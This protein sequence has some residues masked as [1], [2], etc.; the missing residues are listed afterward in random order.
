MAFALLWPTMQ[1]SL[2]AVAAAAL[3][4]GMTVLAFQTGG[5]FDR[6][7]V[8]AAA[9]AWALV[10]LAAVFGRTPLPLSGPGRAA[11]AGLLLL[12][13]WTG[14]SILWAPVAGRAQDDLE[15]VLLYLGFF[16][17]AVAFLRGNG[18]RR[19][20]EPSLV[21]VVLVVV[22]YGL[23]ERLLPGLIELER[24]STSSGRLEQPLT[25][26]NAMGIVAAIGLLL[27]VRVAGDPERSR[28]LRAAAAAGGVV[29][30]FGLYLTFARGALA[31][32]AVGLVV[33]IGLAPTVRP[34]LRSIFVVLAASAVAALVANF[35]PAVKSLERG[36]PGDTAEGLAMLLT[37]TLLAAVAPLIALRRPRRRWP[38][39]H[40]PGRR[41]ITVL[42][43]AGVFVLA[44]V[45][46]VAALEGKPENVSPASG[47][48]PARLASID[49]NR[50]G[51]WKV[52]IRE[53]VDHPVAG[54]GSG[55]FA[56][57]WLKER[58]RE[59][60]A[61]DAHSLYIETAAE[62]G[63]VGLGFLLLFA[64][65]VGIALG[66]L[67]RLSPGAA[68]GLS[69][70]LAAWACHAGL[71]WDWEL[72]AA[73]LPALLLAAAAITGSEDDAARE[74]A[75]QRHDRKPTVARDGVPA[76]ASGELPSRRS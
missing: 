10:A 30:G 63:L 44:G 7:R 22:G 9:G 24:S 4:G 37:L 74:P 34:L 76:A 27:A 53:A 64:A 73:T 31:A 50:Y 71:D 14:L 36:Q 68:T 33:L 39:P 23:S 69:A 25:Y 58:D 49:T 2:P 62:L 45:V 42:T 21:L 52:A 59:D 1:R 67:Y 32:L 66:R 47:T 72:P 55:G 65:G 56:V 46:A 35:L 8:I 19:W 70:G 48:G 13:L 41:P 6:A 20:L 18:I 11:L 75:H 40:L 5:Y 17:A 29:I 38:I 54:L 3:I 43:A 57:V 60:Q 12:C 61:R 16:W 26:W 51:Y 15:R 28:P